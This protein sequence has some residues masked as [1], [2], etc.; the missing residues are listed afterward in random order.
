MRHFR[1]GWSARTRI[2]LRDIRPLLTG[3]RLPLA[4][5]MP[6]GSPAVPHRRDCARSVRR[7]L[8][9][10]MIHAHAAPARSSSITTGRPTRCTKMWLP[11]NLFSVHTAAG[12][13]LAGYESG[14]YDLNGGHAVPK[15]TR[16]E[17][18]KRE[19]DRELDREL[20]DTFPASDPPNITRVPYERRFTS[21]PP[22]NDDQA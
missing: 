6:T 2:L 13:W 15:E 12:N 22:S 3:S 8:L 21:E 9:A 1:P 19:Q 20:E 11:K 10:V 18:T 16:Q 14:A 7:L 5:S 4:T 17:N